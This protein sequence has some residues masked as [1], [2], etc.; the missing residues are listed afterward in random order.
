MQ[1]VSGEA[2][3]SV[4]C[5]VCI[6]A[7]RVWCRSKQAICRARQ[8]EDGNWKI[9]AICPFHSMHPLDEVAE[10]ERPTLKMGNPG[11]SAMPIGSSSNSKRNQSNSP[12]AVDPV[13]GLYKDY[14]A[15]SSG[16]GSVKRRRRSS[17]P[18]SMPF[19]YD[20]KL[21]KEHTQDPTASKLPKLG[22]RFKTVEAFERVCDRGTPIDSNWILCD[23]THEQGAVEKRCKH[24]RGIDCTGDNFR[25]RCEQQDDG[26]W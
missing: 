13:T 18:P 20:E 26:V 11:L 3:L 6:L 2:T 19:P 22:Q 24:T 9:D 4:P 5:Q 12:S 10:L 23:A 14:S 25:V 17:T 7:L 16:K 21:K 1:L 8:Q 15:A